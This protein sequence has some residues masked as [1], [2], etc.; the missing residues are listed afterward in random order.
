VIAVEAPSAEMITRLGWK[1]LQA[2]ET[3]SPEQ[4]EA[5]YMRRSD[6]ELF[7]KPSP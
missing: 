6:A 3:V 4:L 7:A 5:N 2:G 1:K